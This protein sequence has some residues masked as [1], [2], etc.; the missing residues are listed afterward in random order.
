MG[1]FDW[2]RPKPP[3]KC[4]VCGIELMEWQ[5][6]P[7]PVDQPV[8]EECRL[9]ENE[10]KLFRLPDTFSIHSYDCK[11]HKVTARCGVNDGTWIAAWVAEVKDA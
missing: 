4:P 5:G 9:E 8:E 10:R 2:Y 7:Y 1:M 6:V 3:L 11:R